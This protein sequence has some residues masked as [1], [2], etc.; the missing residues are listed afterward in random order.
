MHNMLICLGRKM[1]MGHHPLH[2]WPSCFV[3]MP[4][5]VQPIEDVAVDVKE[6][7]VVACDGAWCVEVMVRNVVHGYV[8][9]SECGTLGDVK[10]SH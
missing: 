5:S 10:V 9:M 6:A 2:I 8:S 1:M 7:L 3:P 4:L